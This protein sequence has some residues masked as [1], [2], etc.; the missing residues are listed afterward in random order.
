MR[1]L[2]GIRPH[3]VRRTRGT[4]L[5]AQP[6]AALSTHLPGAA[7][8]HAALRAR[9]VSPTA[10]VARRAA[11]AARGLGGRSLSEGEVEA[12]CCQRQSLRAGH[13]H[14]KG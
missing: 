5:D 11:A 9:A 6:P 14:V 1:R 3:P 12:M 8:V 4:V 10:A 13:N 2:N 7:H